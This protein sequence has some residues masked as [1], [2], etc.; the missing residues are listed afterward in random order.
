MVEHKLVAL[1][2]SPAAATILSPRVSSSRNKRWIPRHL[3]HFDTTLL[4]PKKRTS[5][6]YI[7][8]IA[9]V[10]GCSVPYRYAYRMP[11]LVLEGLGFSPPIL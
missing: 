3:P 4:A 1:L 7:Y 10:A 9:V 2:I 6:D 11:T 8:T 5:K